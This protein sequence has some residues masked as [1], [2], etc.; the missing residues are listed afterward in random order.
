MQWQLHFANY[1]HGSHM[2]STSSRAVAFGVSAPAVMFTFVIA[3]AV[4]LYNVLL[5]MLWF[6]RPSV[7]HKFDSIGFQL[8]ALLSRSNLVTLVLLFYWIPRSCCVFIDHAISSCFNP[9]ILQCLIPQMW[10]CLHAGI[11]RYCKSLCLQCLHAGFLRYCNVFMPYFPN[12]ELLLC[13][14]PLFLHC[15]NVWKASF[16]MD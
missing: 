8:S 1:L 14:V 15:L 12:L 13:L 16:G 7:P 6:T 3:S 10:Q 4:K 5:F 9:Q 11:H 2:A